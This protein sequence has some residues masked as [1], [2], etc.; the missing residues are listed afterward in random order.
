MKSLRNMLE[1]LE[2][3]ISACF[4]QKK[5]LSFFHERKR[6]LFQNLICEFPLSLVGVRIY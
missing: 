2:T 4:F 6:L 1:S 5:A 3:V